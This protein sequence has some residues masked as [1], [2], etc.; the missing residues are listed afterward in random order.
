MANIKGDGIVHGGFRLLDMTDVGHAG[1]FPHITGKL[2]QLF[3]RSNSIN[4]D[5]AVA[6]VFGPTADAE[7]VRY[8]LREGAEA[9]T[10]NPPSHDVCTSNFTGELRFQG[11][12]TLKA[13]SG[14]KLQSC[15]TR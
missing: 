8:M 6:Q 5:I 14:D 1:A 12:V 13:L 10:L 9:D 11:R 15:G 4:F 3:R 2:R 7:A